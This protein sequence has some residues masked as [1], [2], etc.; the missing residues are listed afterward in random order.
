[1][2]Y[3]QQIIADI[4]S[5]V[6]SKPIKHIYEEDITEAENNRRVNGSFHAF[7]GQVAHHLKSRSKYRLF[8][9]SW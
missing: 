1:M 9:V 6:Y 5:G 7:A 2:T 4:H 3:D 8:Y